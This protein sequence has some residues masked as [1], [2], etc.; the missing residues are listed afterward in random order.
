MPANELLLLHSP[1]LIPSGSVKSETRR[2]TMSGA[3]DKGCIEWK[4]VYSPATGGYIRR[5]NK[6]ARSRRRPSLGAIA[7]G[8]P[9]SFAGTIGDVKGVLMMGA[10]AVTGA[11]VTDKIFGLIAK[12]WGVTGWKRYAAQAATGIAL[13]ILVGKFLKRPRLAASLAVGPVVVAGLQAAA[14]LMNAGPLSAGSM[15]GLGMMSIEPYYQQL[16]GA[17]DLGAMQ[18]GQGVPNWMYTPENEL[19][20]AAASGGY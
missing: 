4:N 17:Q 2:T 16:S 13:G 18:V 7:L 14:E 9:G 20:G 5:C 19:A 11:V 12:N 15:S 8:N 1:D 6:M 10:V 3:G